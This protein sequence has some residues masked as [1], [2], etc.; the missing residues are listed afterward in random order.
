MNKLRQFITILFVSLTFLFL[1]NRP[2][3]AQT[4]SLVRDSVQNADGTNFSG[5]LII[6]WQGFTSATGSTVAPHSTA[7][8]IVNGYLSVLLVPTTN[9]SPGAAY[10]ATYE[11][12]DGTVLWTETWQ[13]APSWTPLTLNQVR[14]P[15][16]GGSSGSSGGS[17][18][19]ST[20]ALPIQ[21]TDVAGLQAALETRPQ[22]GSVYNMLHAAM[23]D[24]SGNVASVSGNNSDCVHVDGN[25]GPCGSVTGNFPVFVDGEAPSGSADGT[26]STFLLSQPPSPTSSLE[27]YR[28]GV[29]QR[30]GVD[31]TLSGSTISDRPSD[32]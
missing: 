8:N 16:G 31:Y 21:I 15:N 30:N 32:V 20:I 4:L 2:A 27:F 5:K 23:V 29:L 19:G 22:K 1:T 13:V 18:S 14:Q 12:N 28:N 11:S 3:S 26:N 10:T 17:G 7:I 9:A 25:S 24:A 6:S